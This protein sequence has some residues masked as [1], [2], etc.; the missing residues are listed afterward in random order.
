VQSLKSLQLPQAEPKFP[1]AWT[2]WVMQSPLLLM[3]SFAPE[4]QTAPLAQW[5][6]PFPQAVPMAAWVHVLRNG[7]PVET[8]QTWQTPQSA[9]VV[10]PLPA[11]CTAVPISVAAPDGCLPSLEDEH[12]TIDA[13]RAR[14]TTTA[15]QAR[16]P[17]AETSQIMPNRRGPG[18]ARQAD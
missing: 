2:T 8:V 6:A 17:A 7:P 9:S 15:N 1:H 16:R 3:Q 12:P 13:K 5:P 14:I 11:A 4:Q 18:Q 10:Q